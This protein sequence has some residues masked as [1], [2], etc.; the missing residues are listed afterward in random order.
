[1]RTRTT[2]ITWPA[3][4]A[5]N[6]RPSAVVSCS[7][8]LRTAT[9]ATTSI[10]GRAGG[11]ASA[12]ARAGRRIGV[13]Y[14]VLGNHDGRLFAT[15]DV[16]DRSFGRSG[17]GTRPRDDAPAEPTT[18]P[19]IGYTGIAVQDAAYMVM[20]PS[21]A[22]G[23]AGRSGTNRCSCIS[24][25]GSGPEPFRADVA[26]AID[27][28]IDQKVAMMDA[29]VA[30]LR[31]ASVARRRAGSGAGRRH[32]AQ[33]LAQ[34][35]SDGR[36]DRRRASRTGQAVRPGHSHGDALRRS[37]PNLRRRRAAG[38]ADARELFPF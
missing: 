32:G 34:T 17:V 29:H 12:E 3:V 19:T 11:A 23:Y 20:V 18:I 1:M 16:R 26:I 25:T 31:V 14:E 5:R 21:L 4:S 22:A 37:L 35:H 2:A 24:R 8:R 15:T 27:D 7:C 36:A 13:D 9:P 6:G 33:G 30:V 10:G 38:R 28:V